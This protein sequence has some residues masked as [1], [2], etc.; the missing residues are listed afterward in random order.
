MEGPESPATHTTNTY[1]HKNFRNYIQ[2]HLSSD[3]QIY[4]LK[5]PTVVD[6][7]CGGIHALS[8]A[9]KMHR[10]EKSRVILGYISILKL[11][12]AI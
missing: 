5:N 2:L 8:S 11:T 1:T 12:W 6:V 9:L 10:Q 3:T 4:D 7:W